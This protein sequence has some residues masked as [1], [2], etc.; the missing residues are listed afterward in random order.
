MPRNGLT[1][2]QKGF[3]YRYRTMGGIWLAEKLEVDVKQIYQY[4]T[5][6]QFSVKKDGKCQ[7]KHEVAMKRMK[8]TFSRWPKAYFRYKPLLIKRDGLKCHYCLKDITAREAQIDHVIAKVRGGSDAPIN[9][10][11]ACA[12]CNNLKST[13]CYTCP[14]F[15]SQINQ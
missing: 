6:R 8:T 9:L 2:Y 15:R 13:L 7:E 14:E 3:I 12:K 1:E 11:L 10:V 4:A 5:D